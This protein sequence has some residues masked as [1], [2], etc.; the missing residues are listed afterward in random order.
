MAT[1]ETADEDL[2]AAHVDGDREAF[3]TL[4]A[5]HRERLWA[6]ALRTTGDP[7]L[8]ADGLQEGMIAAFRRADS[9]R[10]DARVTTWLHRVVVNACLDL[11]RRRS[12]R[13][14][15]PLPDDTDR[16]DRLGGG[17]RVRPGEASDPADLQ[18]RRE[19]RDLV[20][21]ALLRLPDEQRAAVVL[22]DMEGY[23]VAE[24]AVML[25]CAVGT[26]KSRCSRA[27]ARLAVLLRGLLD[28]DETEVTAP[29]GNPPAPRTVRSETPRAPPAEPA[30]AD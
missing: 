18:V 19:R 15:D 30:P 6:V 24:V 26:V 17:D 28:E 12:V 10:G 27:R 23:P 16:L 1:D 20:Q 5:R 11:L 14:T 13:R 3:A 29:S 9:F 25:D 21:A 7:E 2:L 22:V 4:F 8:A